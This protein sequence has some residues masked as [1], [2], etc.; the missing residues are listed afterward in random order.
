MNVH[1][2]MGR[3][4]TE[5][6]H[7]QQKRE[8]REKKKRSVPR[9]RRALNPLTEL[10]ETERK[11]GKEE[12]KSRDGAPALRATITRPRYQLPVSGDQNIGE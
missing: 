4:K 10:V 1:R 5:Y 8:E 6:P 3:K 12:G 11:L 2:K 7:L 9:D